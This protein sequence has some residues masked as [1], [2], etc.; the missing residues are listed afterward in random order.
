MAVDELIKRVAE[1]TGIPEAKAKVAVDT[2]VDFL[3][4]RLPA[5][6]ASQVDAV[7]SGASMTDMA[8]G[9]G[10]MLGKK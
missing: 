2:V 1:K 9:L 3:K 6:V 10:G 8:K 4:Q 7:L 5:P